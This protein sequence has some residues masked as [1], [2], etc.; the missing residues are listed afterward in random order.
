MIILTHEI[1]PP[2]HFPKIIRDQNVDNHQ[3]ESEDDINLEL[4]ESIGNEE[5]GVVQVSILNHCLSKSNVLF[6]H[7]I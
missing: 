6:T 2:Q 5:W 3:Q 4:R 7:S 1:H